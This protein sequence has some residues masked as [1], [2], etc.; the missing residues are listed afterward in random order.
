MFEPT[1][2]YRGNCYV[3][4]QGESA[5]V[6]N[7]DFTPPDILNPCSLGHIS[8]LDNI[9]V[10]D[11]RKW[12]DAKDYSTICYV[13][14]D[15]FGNWENPNEDEKV[16]VS[17]TLYP[18]KKNCMV[19]DKCLWTRTLTMRMALEYTYFSI[20]QVSPLNSEWVGFV[21]LI[22]FTKEDYEL[23]GVLVS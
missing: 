1:F 21:E 15:V 3:Y 11:F 23:N 7:R 9:T 14:I 20:L 10:L 19:D 22:K 2:K 8:G 4:L 6:F 13:E 5:I 18:A 16:T 12:T 17:I